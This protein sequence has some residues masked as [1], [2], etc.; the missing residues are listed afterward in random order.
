MTE[1]IIELRHW[2]WDILLMGVVLILL[3][4]IVFVAGAN[5]Q[6]KINSEQTLLNSPI[7]DNSSNYVITQQKE[8]YYISNG[9]LKAGNLTKYLNTPYSQPQQQSPEADITI[10]TI[11]NIPTKTDYYKVSFNATLVVP[12]GFAMPYESGGYKAYDL[13]ADYIS[14]NPPS[15]IY[16]PMTSL[17]MV[18]VVANNHDTV[19]Y[20][21][22]VTWSVISAEPQQKRVNVRENDNIYRMY[23]FNSSRI[24]FFPMQTTLGAIVL[25]FNVQDNG[26]P[27]NNDVYNMYIKNTINPKGTEVKVANM[28][29]FGEKDLF[30]SEK[31]NVQYTFLINYKH[32]QSSYVEVT[33]KDASNNKKVS[34]IEQITIPVSQSDKT[35]HIILA[36]KMLKTLYLPPNN[37]GGINPNPIRIGLIIVRNTH[38]TVW[39]VTAID[40]MAHPIVYGGN[41][42]VSPSNLYSAVAVILSL[43]IAFGIGIYG[44]TLD[45]GINSGEMF[46]IGMALATIGAVIVSYMI[47][48]IWENMATLTLTFLTI[49]FFAIWMLFR[50]GRIEFKGD[51]D[52]FF[53]NHGDAVFFATLVLTIIQYIWGILP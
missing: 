30:Y 31:I 21:D 14:P 44:I 27:I 46:A 45:K 51:I 25:P 40:Y 11:K 24:T 17:G 18:G 33:Y 13:M 52:E 16:I 42:A 38:P 49:G 34:I 43:L 36:N 28:T 7:T 39:N 19:S 3:G 20:N 26:F 12:M 8:Y 6:V 2:M 1:K 32:P 50:S 9:G 47:P 23:Y 10:V 35:I 4:G 53:A 37:G 5:P 15:Y 41:V 48:S 29:R 22:E